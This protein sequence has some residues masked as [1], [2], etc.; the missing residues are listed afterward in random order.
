M[1]N[2]LVL[3]PKAQEDLENIFSIGRWIKKYI[4]MFF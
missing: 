1:E 4:G 3:L 2:R